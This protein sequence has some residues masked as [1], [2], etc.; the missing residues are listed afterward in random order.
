MIGLEKSPYMLE[1]NSL[2]SQE[3]GAGEETSLDIFEESIGE[4]F[5]QC[6][7]DNRGDSA[8]KEEEGKRAYMSLV[9]DHVQCK[10]TR[11]RTSKFSHLRIREQD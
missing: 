11:A 5:A 8:N 4:F 1:R 7:S 6:P 2:L 9:E 10:K 3:L